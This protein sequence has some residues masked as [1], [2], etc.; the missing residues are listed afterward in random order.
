MAAIRAHCEPLPAERVP[1][2][3]ALGRVL[4][5]A[6]HAP[7][8]IPACDR[9]TRDGYA[10]LQHDT[11]EVFQVV[12]TLFAADWKPRQLQPGEAVHVAT[13]AAL[14]GEGLRVVMQENV[15]R[16]GIY[17]RIVEPESGLN[18]R[19]CGEEVQRGAQLITAGTR[20]DAGKL[21][22]LAAVGWVQPQVNARLR[23]VHCTTGDEV[24]PPEQ[25][26]GPGQIRDSN[27]ILIRS[28]MQNIGCELFKT[29]LPED[30]A[31]TKQ[32]C[33]KLKAEIDRADLLLISGGAS[34]GEKD[35]TQRLLAGLGFDIHFS[36]VN[37]RPGKPLIF[38]TQG[39]RAAFG[40]PGNPLSHFVCFHFAV[41]TAL[42]RFTGETPPQFRRG[43]LAAPLL[44]AACPRET[45][46]PARR[47]WAELQP[48]PRTSSGD[49]TS[50]AWA[51][52]LLRV[53]ANCP[54]LAAG[55]EVDFLPTDFQ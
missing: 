16:Q 35:F 10:I 47:E 30:F 37:M 42:A 17:F 45:L 53:P 52:A 14:P 29:H 46:W 8:D 50:F 48:L 9:S 3:A 51:N 40:L 31:H 27:S 4:R 41:A 1:L 49:V 23:V 36:Q 5:E 7:E 15:E 55:T 44:A 21:A 32:E 11:S 34:V 6:V 25:T 33:E 39:R 2:A 18:R 54:T 43:W 13:G 12:D 22:L 28:L 20:L 38:S 19:Q 26:P 24:V